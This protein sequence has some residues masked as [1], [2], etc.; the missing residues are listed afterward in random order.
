M[1]FVSRNCFLP[2]NHNL[3]IVGI[4]KK[5]AKDQGFEHIFLDVLA[6]GKSPAVTRFCANYVTLNEIYGGRVAESV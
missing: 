3:E 4:I 1:L 6:N 5:T 2:N